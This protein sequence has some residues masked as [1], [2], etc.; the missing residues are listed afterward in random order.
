MPRVHTV[1]ESSIDGRAALVLVSPAGLAVTFVPGAGMVASSLTLHGTELL[2]QRGGL[3]DYVKR[4]KTFGIPLLHPWANRLDGLRYEAAGRAVEVDPEFAPVRLDE[5]GLPN[6]GV[7]GPSPLWRVTGTDDGAAASVHA[8]LDYGPAPLLAAFPFPHHLSVEA[9]LEDRT[10]TVVT[11]LRAEEPVPISFGWHP[12]LTLPGL[13][14]AEWEVDLGVRTRGVLD[15][16][17]IPTGATEQAP[18]THG[19]LGER[20]F[21]D[22]Y[23]ELA[24]PPE[25]SVA[26]GGG[27]IVVRLEDGYRCTQVYGPPEQDLICFEPMTA[28]VNALVS[29][30][31]LTLSDDYAARFSI[32]V[33]GE[34]GAA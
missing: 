24:D 29:G 1:R 4:G 21:D 28:P 11:T 14:R 25:L 17:G 27:R 9:R 34:P 26:G 19:A 32:A 3:I 2:F 23:P 13:P 7:L 22:F 6:H 20:P 31:R 18:F 8:E 10:L 5:N 30:D 33:E 12:Y 16:R 15:A